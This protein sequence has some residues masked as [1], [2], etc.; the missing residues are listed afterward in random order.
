MAVHIPE[1]LADL[2]TRQKKAFASLALVRKNGTPHVSVIWFDYDGEHI[3]FNTARG[4]LKDNVLRRHP[5]VALEIRDPED[6]Y[7]YLLLTG[8]VVFESEEGGF[9]EICDLNEKYHGSR[10]FP[11]RPGQVR[12]TYKMR[13]ELVVPKN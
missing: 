2:L 8:P 3:L 5:T 9:E 10:D 1:R 11:M 7:R 6:S 4:R 12:V 13:P